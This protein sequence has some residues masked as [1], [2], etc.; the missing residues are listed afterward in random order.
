MSLHVPICNHV[1]SLHWDVTTHQLALVHDDTYLHWYMTTHQLAL[2]HDNTYLHWY[3][4]THQPALV[5]DNTPACIGTWSHTNL[6]WYMTTHQPALVQ[7]NT[8]TC[9]GTWQHTSLHWYMTTLACIIS[10]LNILVP[11]FT[12][13]A[14]VSTLDWSSNSRWSG[15]LRW[16]NM[17]S[18]G[19][20][21]EES[22]LWHA[23]AIMRCPTIILI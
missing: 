22:L 15:R 14:I 10:W 21:M 4:T 3:M 1:P 12:S 2:V 7:D 23:S 16:T 8:P 20:E 13:L 6:H 5:Q 11:G 9:I 18:V 17:K 19:R